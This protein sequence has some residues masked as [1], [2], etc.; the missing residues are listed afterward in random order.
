MI[1]FS[2]MLYKISVLK[3]PKDFIYVATQLFYLIVRLDIFPLS[4][5]IVSELKMDPPLGKTKDNQDV[6][7]YHNIK[8]PFLGAEVQASA[9]YPFHT[10]ITWATAVVLIG[11]TWAPQ[12]LLPE[13][14]PP[15]TH[16]GLM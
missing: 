14:H 7:S 11:I 2:K 10:F 8:Y 6:L 15:E 5:Y 13:S 9:V 3:N 16:I 4:R 1:P 12:I